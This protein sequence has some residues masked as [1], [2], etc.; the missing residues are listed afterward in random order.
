MTVSRVVNETGYVSA[1][2]R[3]K[4]LRA[5]AELGYLPN[6]HARGLRSRRSGTIALIVSDITNP[7]FTT[8]ARG[9]E[10]AARARGSLV[11]FG[12]TDELESEESR[13]L[14]LLVQK[15]VDGVLLVPSHRGERALEIAASHHLPV[16]I[17]D[18]RGPA[19]CDTV[20][21]D[22]E[23]GAYDL[24]VHL[25]ELGHLRYAILA[26]PEDVSTSDDRIAGFRRSIGD[27]PCALL[28]GAMTV[29]DGARL[30]QGVLALEPR[31]TAIFAVNNFLA[32][33][34]QNALLRAGVAVP[35]EVSLVGFDDLPIQMVATPF[36]TVAVQPAYE[37]GLQAAARLFDRIAEPGLPNEE[38]VLETSISVRGSS[39]LAKAS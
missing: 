5:V 2:T 9:V 8:I 14:E 21:C 11:L 18:R 3:E 29:Q 16:V 34:A 10:D 24:G 22:S 36:L 15:G 7:Y 4:V 13:Y 19:G 30:A 35:Q 28:H 1:Q 33:G 20:R 31:P 25:R 39:G 17:V 37:L 38:V 32:I 6:Q 26:G 12:N 23:Q 27:L